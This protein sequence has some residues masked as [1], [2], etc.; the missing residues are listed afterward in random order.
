MNPDPNT[1]P[2]SSTPNTNPQSG[3]QPQ[4][5][6]PQTSSIVPELGNETPMSLEKTEEHSTPKS[7]IPDLPPLNFSGNTSFLSQ[8]VVTPQT[9]TPAENANLGFSSNM[10]TTPV[11]EPAPAP[12]QE[13]A[14]TPTPTPVAPTPT[15]TPEPTPAPAT[16]PVN[17]VESM[18]Q[19][20]TNVTPA[21]NPKQMIATN[22]NQT[23]ILIIAG[24][25]GVLVV[26]VGGIIL[27]ISNSATTQ[28]AVQT[29][30]ITEELVRE[31]QPSQTIPVQ[32]QITTQEYIAVAN[33]IKTRLS[34]VQTTYPVNIANNNINAENVKSASNE[35]YSIKDSLSGTVIGNQT[36]TQLNTELIAL[37]DQM[38]KLHDEIV[39]E[40]GTGTSLSPQ[41]R[42]QIL[43]NYNNLNNS[44]NA[45]LNEIPEKLQTITIQ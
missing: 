31:T 5:N 33:N 1:N 13:A 10:A 28:P 9:Q 11:S 27:L 44:I 32:S 34:Q 17:P 45:K 3:N 36:A 6:T 39:T 24:A 42:T 35:L 30:V 15:P 2:N 14:P 37:I 22:N 41:A 26:L 18:V 21:Q 4:N 20:K 29:P 23:K 38:A 12:V 7:D 40:L 25:L 43:A 19:E 8:P 16:S